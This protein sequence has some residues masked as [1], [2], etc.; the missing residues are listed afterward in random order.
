MREN[1]EARIDSPLPS[2]FLFLP[3]FYERGEMGQA[4]KGRGEQHSTLGEIEESYSPLKAHKLCH[5]HWDA[6]CVLPLHKMPVG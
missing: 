3:G 6:S 1:G 4:G 5:Y 2:P